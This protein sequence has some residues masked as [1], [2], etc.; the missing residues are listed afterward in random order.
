MRNLH[1]VG[2]ARACPKR[3]KKEERNW[4]GTSIANTSYSCAVTAI[5]YLYK[6][7]IIDSDS[8][9]PAA[10]P[11]FVYACMQPVLYGIYRKFHA[12]I[13]I[14]YNVLFGNTNLVR[15]NNGS[16]FT[17]ASYPGLPRLLSLQFA[18]A[19]KAWGGLGTRLC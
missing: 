18:Q 12:E 8:V 5:Q 4:L 14:L 15:H 9:H 2:L 16:V 7:N 13:T 11:E 19:I 10:L 1:A 6:I 17:V 3:C